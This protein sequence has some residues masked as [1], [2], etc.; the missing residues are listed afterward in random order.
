MKR[1]IYDE[2]D[3]TFGQAMLTLRTRIGLTQ[4]GLADLLG[5]SRRSVGEW[6]AGNSYPKVER[7]KQLIELAIKQQA[8]PVGSEAQAIRDLWTA[9]RQKT[10]LDEQWLSSLLKPQSTLPSPAATPLSE[11]D[12]SCQSIDVLPA[13]SGPLI[14]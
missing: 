13:T 7:L 3:Y 9:A 6:E 11:E 1:S 5:V 12:T 8:F 4:S 2:R 10:V 14:D